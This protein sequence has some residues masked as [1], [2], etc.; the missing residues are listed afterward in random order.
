MTPTHGIHPICTGTVAVKVPFLTRKGGEIT[1]KLR[2]IAS[3]SFT[4]PFP[5]L[6]WLIEHEE[7]DFLID[8]GMSEASSAP[9]YL[10]SI[11]RFD[12]WL[13]NRMC[14]FDM[15][16][17]FGLG[18]QLHRVRARGTEG[19]RIIM[20]HLHTDHISGLADVPGV[21]VLVN[22]AEWQRPSGA[23][24]RLLATLRPVCFELQ[25]DAKSAFTASY[26]LTRAG[27]LFVVAA[28]GHTPNHCA[29]ILLRAGMTFLFTGDAV[30]NQGQ[31]LRNEIAGSHTSV[32]LALATM[33]AM[34][35]F[36]REGPTIVLP[37]HDSDSERRLRAIEIFPQ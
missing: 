12:A 36:T 6:A 10:Q 26:P 14:R 3:Q 31:L 20:T 13:S 16:P 25:Q 19:L 28:P 24:K 5:V 11:G 37:S 1:S 22:Q 32:D 2:I 15:A 21:E 33:K 34:R 23:P 29:V 35:H 18:P 9:G 7:G 27:D 8:T 30:Y 4:L 17:G